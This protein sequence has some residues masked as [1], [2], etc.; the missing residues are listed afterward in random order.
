MLELDVFSRDRCGY[1]F[2]THLCI[3]SNVVNKL[4]VPI[5]CAGSGD[6]PVSTDVLVTPSDDLIDNITS[7]DHAGNA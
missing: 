5:A 7:T 6:I 4:D 3:G 2:N 1:M